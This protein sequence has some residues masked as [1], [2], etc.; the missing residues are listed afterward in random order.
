MKVAIIGSRKLTNVNISEYIPKGVTKIISG[1]ANG[2]DALAEKYA[3]EHNI[4]K[5]IIE[6][7]YRRFAKGAPLKRN[8]TIVKEADLILAFFGRKV[9][10]N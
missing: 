6:P 5:L 10:R 4:P 3:D 9:S 1:G 7:N 2:I 8:E